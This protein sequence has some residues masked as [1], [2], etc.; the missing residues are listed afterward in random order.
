MKVVIIKHENS[1]QMYLFKVPQDYALFAGE[2]VLVETKNKGHQLG[3]CLCDSFELPKNQDAKNEIFKAFK[4]SS[5]PCSSV[6]G[7]YRLTEFTQKEYTNNTLTEKDMQDDED[8]VKEHAKEIIDK[9]DCVYYRD[10]H[11]GSI[12]VC[13]L[14]S[15]LNRAYPSKP[16]VDEICNV[17]NCPLTNEKNEFRA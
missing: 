3:R 8:T 13:L 17:C 1:G 9:H 2:L 7:V 4:I 12:S 6:I 14:L 10:T 15:S 5:D 16:G 11:N